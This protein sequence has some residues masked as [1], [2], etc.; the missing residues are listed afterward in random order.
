MSALYRRESGGDGMWVH[1]GEA[2]AIKFGV[3]F[4]ILG[5][6]VLVIGGS[7]LHSRLRLRQ[8]RAPLAYHRVRPAPPRRPSPAR[9]R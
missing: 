7:Y 9:R 8:N 1:S 3:L 2:T 4:G 6:A 5:A